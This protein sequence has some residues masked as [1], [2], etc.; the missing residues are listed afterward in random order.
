M[1]DRFLP[2][3]PG[4]GAPV[5]TEQPSTPAPWAEQEWQAGAQRLPFT[6]FLNALYR[7]GWLFLALVLVTILAAGARAS[8]QIPLYRATATLELNPAPARVVQ[9]GENG[10]DEPE[11]SDWDFLALQL[12][13]IKSRNVAERVARALNLSR[14]E[15]FLGKE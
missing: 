10:V 1:N 2:S 13:L 11:Q 14:D 4:G 8:Q 12:G 6:N 3:D 9:M 5:P 7:W 15:V